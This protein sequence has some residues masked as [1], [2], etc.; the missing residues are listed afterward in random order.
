MPLLSF[1]LVLDCLG[2]RIL[3]KRSGAFV[4]GVIVLERSPESL[5]DKMATRK[6]TDG[7]IAQV[8]SLVADHISAQRQKY[9]AR[10][11]PLTAQQRAAVAPFFASELLGNTRLLVLPGER[12]ANPD[13]YPM[14]RDL[15]FNNLPDHSTMA[16]ITFCDVVV[17]HEPFSNGLLFHELVHVEQY[18]QLGIPRFADLYVRGFLNGGSYEMIPLE[19]NAYTL[20]DRFRREPHRSFEVHQEVASWAAEGKL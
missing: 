8:C 14:L 19:V 3:H 17:S 15:G 20:E 6:L 9:A 5:T 2:L 12:V 11:V 4:F 16:A 10:G 13:F 18:R 7:Q 1:P